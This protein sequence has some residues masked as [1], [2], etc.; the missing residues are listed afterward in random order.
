MKQGVER[1][2]L[3]PLSFFSHSMEPF[4]AKRGDGL[5]TFCLI[6]AAVIDSAPASDMR[7]TGSVVFTQVC[8]YRRGQCR[9]DQH[10]RDMR[11][12]HRCNPYCHPAPTEKREHRAHKNRHQHRYGHETYRAAEVVET[13]NTVR[14]GKIISREVIA[15]MAPKHDL[16]NGDHPLCT[17]H[18]KV[19]KMPSSDPVTSVNGDGLVCMEHGI[20]VLHF[21]CFALCAHLEHCRQILA[22]EIVRHGRDAGFVGDV[23]R[24][25]REREPIDI[26]GLGGLTGPHISD[27]GRAKDGDQH[28]RT[29]PQQ[30]TP[31]HSEAI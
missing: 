24:E 27:S 2:V 14:P 1:V 5:R 20:P 18:R 12:G 3:A 29:R 11:E 31:P 16:G 21:R 30:G 7:S 6:V 4:W 25:W 10:R 9:Y 28:D 13:A 8:R 26:G 22:G 17:N 23:Q 15:E 19:L